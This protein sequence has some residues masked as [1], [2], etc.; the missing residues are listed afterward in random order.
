MTHSRGMVGIVFQ[1][2]NTPAGHPTIVE[3]RRAEGDNLVIRTTHPFLSLH[4]QIAP[5]SCTQ[6]KWIANPP[7]SNLNHIQCTS[8][9]SIP[10][11]A[12]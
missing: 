6:R 3:A 12:A 5:S 1:V 9:V 10:A 4:L 11:A 7:P 8:Y 2:F